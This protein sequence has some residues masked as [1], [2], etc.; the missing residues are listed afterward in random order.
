MTEQENTPAKPDRPLPAAIQMAQRALDVLRLEDAEL[1]TTLEKILP[2]FA[3]TMERAKKEITEDYLVEQARLGATHLK[4]RALQSAVKQAVPPLEK[5]AA[6]ALR[7]KTT[8]ASRNVYIGGME[9]DLYENVKE[10]FSSTTRNTLRKIGIVNKNP[11]PSPYHP[12]YD[13]PLPFSNTG[14]MLLHMICMEKADIFTDR[15]AF[16]ET[17][18]DADKK[19]VI[20]TLENEIE[21]EGA[22]EEGFTWN[23]ALDEHRTEI[24][25]KFLPAF[26]DAIFNHR[27]IKTYIA[28]YAVAN[29]NVD[30]LQKLVDLSPELVSSRTSIMKEAANTGN[31]ELLSCLLPQWLAHCEN[32]A[33][34]DGASPVVLTDV[35]RHAPL[36]AL[37]FMIEQTKDLPRDIIPNAELATVALLYLENGKVEEARYLCSLYP[38]ILGKNGPNALRQAISKC[39]LPAA[40]FLAEEY[41]VPFD[42]S[43]YCTGG[44]MTTKAEKYTMVRYLNRKTGA[45]PEGLLGSGASHACG[46]AYAFMR[47]SER[48]QKT[49]RRDPPLGCEDFPSSYYRG[50]TFETVAEILR[51]EGYAGEHANKAAMQATALFQSEERVLQYLELWGK[52]SRAPLHDLVYALSYPYREREPVA[53]NRDM[54]DWGDAVLKC[55]PEMEKIFSAFGNQLEGPEKSDDGKSWSL[56]RTRDKAALFAYARAHVN[57]SLATLFFKHSIGPERFE[58]ALELTSAPMQKKDIPDISIDGEKFGMPGGKFVRL[59]DGDLRGLILGELTDCCQSVDKAGHDCAVHGYSSP[60]GGFYVVQNADEKIIAQTWAWRG[61]KGE[62]CFDTL[63]TLGQNVQDDQW[64]KILHEIGVELTRRDE[65]T[66]TRLTVGLGGDTPDS[67]SASFAHTSKPATPIAYKGYRESQNQ[68]TVWEKPK[69]A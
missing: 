67:L 13:G 20:L 3:V 34:R 12:V 19:A 29:H 61:T 28:A 64:G 51:S 43:Y 56:A 47:A 6:L 65:H 60:N 46:E 38:Q 48:W 49:V 10:I 4:T 14:S 11:I 37:K 59:P 40:R 17:Y 58:H 7:L 62:M 68:L 63:E 18:R 54:N 26:E 21:K 53:R 50:R 39:N 5:Y 69:N 9:K 66:V 25:E 35:I 30:L 24:M 16:H 31:T 33:R 23:V 41:G 1:A 55:G 42:A 27:Y 36:P 8:P 44:P 2:S 32:I 57:P 52:Q 22:A 45:L 15:Q